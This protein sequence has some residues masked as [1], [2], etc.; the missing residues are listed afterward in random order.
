[1]DITVEEMVEMINEVINNLEE[2][3]SETYMISLEL[4]HQLKE[5]LEST[6]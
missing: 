3:D 5:E 4:A 6:L 2:W 1:M